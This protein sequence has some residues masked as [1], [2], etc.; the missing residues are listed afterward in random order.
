MTEGARIGWAAAVLA[1]YLLF[2]LAIWAARRR[3]SRG[4]ARHG[5]KPPVLVVHASQTGTAQGIAEATAG[6]L[7]R[8]GVPV[9][10]LRLRDAEHALRDP[11]TRDV[12]VIAAT[13]GDGDPPESAQAFVGRVRDA[14]ASL[15]H[16]RFALLA[17][18]DSSYR[19]FCGFGLALDRWLRQAGA[20][21]AA[22]PVLVDRGDPAALRAWQA[23]LRGFGAD[24]ALP[25]WAPAPYDRWRLAERARLNPASPHAAVWRLR[26]VPF[27]GEPLP[28]WQAGDIAEIEPGPP[29]ASDLPAHR[30]Y[31]IAS[32]PADGAVELVVRER[33]DAAGRLGPASAWL[34]RD[35]AVGGAVGLRLRPNPGFRAPDGEP[36]LVL[37]GAGTGIAGLAAHLRSRTVGGGAPCWLLFGERSAATD[38]LYAAEIDG[39][40]AAGTLARA[41]LVWSQDGDGYVQDRLRAEAEAVRRWVADGAAILVCGSRAG[42]GEGVHRA[43]AEVLGAEALQALTDGGR[44]RRDVY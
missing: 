21:A 32:V 1:G 27:A 24:P 8:S 26:L 13:T 22:D 35:A 31:S 44:Y 18:G 33:R 14:P 5:G 42:L 39:W 7:R 17:L 6:L 38:A 25:D 30:E 9:T 37:I 2:C 11:A 12:L 36:P 10:L 40:R 16:L 41:D 4:V 43:L 20:E 34:L 23:L 3:R 19:R 15:D 28:A 29:G